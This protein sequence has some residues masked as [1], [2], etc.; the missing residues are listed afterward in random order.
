HEQRQQVHAARRRHL[1]THDHV[2]GIARARHELTRLHGPLH[3]VV[4]GDGDDVEP[5]RQRRLHDRTRAAQP[6]TVGRMNMRVTATQPLLMLVHVRYTHSA[7][8]W[9][10]SSPTAGTPA[11]P[12]AV[13][14]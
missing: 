2:E 3:T 8:P 7:W 14:T 4:I 12:V 10:G 11:T 6:V 13:R 1:S 9:F 5:P